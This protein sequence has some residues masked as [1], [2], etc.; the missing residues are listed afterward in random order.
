MPTANEGR[1]MAG[2]I[3][4]ATAAGA[5]AGA[6]VGHAAALE[7]RNAAVRVVVVPEAREDVSVTITHANAGLPLS[8]VTGPQG[9]ALVDGGLGLG[10]FGSRPVRCG[11]AGP[12]GW[13][14]VWGA[15][16]VA[17]EDLP[18]IVARVPLNAVVAADAAVFGEVGP[19]DG[20]ALKAAS[21]GAWT[22]A[23][24]KGALMIDNTGSA[25][26]RTGE[27]AE[28]TLRVSGSGDIETRAAARRL[29]AWVSGS[30]DIGVEQ[31]SGP[32]EA[33]VAGSGSIRI[34]G[35][36]ASSLQARTTGSGDI[37]YGGRADAAAAEAT[38]SGAVRLAGV[39]QRLDVKLTG[40]GDMTVDE[41]A[42][43]AVGARLSGSGDLRISRGHLSSLKTSISGSGGV[44][45]GGVA[46]RLEARTSGSGWVRVDRVDGPI[47]TASTGSGR[48]LIA[49]R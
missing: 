22:V 3:G 43:A 13:M 45:F 48:V 12:G 18:Q 38:G 4:L 41:A 5:L 31:A 19:A 10:P 28:M 11:P 42:G 16:R 15:G 8:V 29:A 37:A 30:G 26:I 49:E 9:R 17:Y 27:A 21:C 34:A 20:L 2:W 7:I 47:D 35:G 24:V 14:L 44:S 6:G 36:Q 39:S 33:A 23:N 46:D 32:I 25:R 1:A 40:S